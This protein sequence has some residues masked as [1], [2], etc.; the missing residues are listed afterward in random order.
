MRPVSSVA[1]R[2]ASSIQASMSTFPVPSSCTM[3]GTR[4]SALNAT[5]AM[6]SSST[7]AMVV[8]GGP[9]SRRDSRGERAPSLAI[10]VRDSEIEPGAAVDAL[11]GDGVD[12]ALAQDEVLL[13]ADL[14]LVAVLG[15]EQHRVAGLEVAH[16]GP[17]GDDL[18]P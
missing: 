7:V 15:V 17:D 10:A 4:P 9:P 14:D 12:V 11:G 3:A 18:G 8:A 6:S 16:V 13:T 5:S 2:A 1:R